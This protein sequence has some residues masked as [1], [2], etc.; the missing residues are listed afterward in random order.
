MKISKGVLT[1][2]SELQERTLYTVR[3]QD[4]TACQLIIEHPA[5]A[6]WSLVSGSKQPEE[7][8]PG[9]S[10]FRIEV[11]AKATASLPVEESHPEQTTYQLSDLSDDNIALFLRQRTISGEMAQALQKITAQKAIVSKLE[12]EMSN[13]QKDI[14]RIVD[15]QGRLRENMKTLRGSAEEKAFLQRYTRQLGAR[16]TTGYS[17]QE[18]SGHRGDTRQCK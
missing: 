5:R 13:R 4:D 8:A 10:R 12:E 6:G 18:D 16:N 3:S 9:V 2:I 11:P 14:E 17:A 1:L 7:Q 15:D